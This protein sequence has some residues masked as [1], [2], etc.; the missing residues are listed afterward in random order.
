MAEPADI[1]SAIADP[2]RRHIIEMLAASD[3][4]AG[5]VAKAV[6][7]MSRPAV[8]KHLNIL[9]NAGVIVTEKRGRVRINRLQVTAL[10]EVV[11][12]TSTMG[13]FWEARLTTLRETIEAD[14][15]KD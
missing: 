12:W 3:M 10:D 15:E 9:R 8:V 5:D 13:R 6:G 7:G 2:T 4:A 14:S 11:Q 1:F